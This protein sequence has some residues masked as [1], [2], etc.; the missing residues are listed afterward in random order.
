VGVRMGGPRGCTC[1]SVGGFLIGWVGCWVGVGACVF[2]RV[3]ARGHW[4]V[5]NLVCVC[6]VCT[7][8]QR[9]REYVCVDQSCEKVS[10]H[11]CLVM[12]M[13]ECMCVCVRV[14]V[15]GYQNRV[16]MHHIVHVFIC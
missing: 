11:V 13:F 5:F 10:V 14:C 1:G 6:V 12:C 2:V 9:V 16:C 4:C 3:F 7:C 15:R 8:V